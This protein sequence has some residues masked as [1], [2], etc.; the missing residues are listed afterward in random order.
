MVTPYA[1]GALVRAG[2][3]A[4]FVEI[5]TL[6]GAGGVLVLT[7][8][9]DDESLGCGAALAAACDTGVNVTVV[10]LTD[11]SASHP[12][13]EK[14]PPKRLAGLRAT[15]LEAA[16]GRLT[17]GSGGVRFLGC[18][19]QGVPAA[20][21]DRDSLVEQL[22]SLVDQ[23]GVT[24]LWTTWRQDPHIDHQQAAMLA[25]EVWDR[26]SHLVQWQF[27]IWGRFTDAGL[28]AGDELLRFAAAHYAGRKR[29]AIASHETQMTGLI[30][31]A[32]NGFVMDAAAQAHF[33]AFD[34]LFIRVAR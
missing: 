21:A 2:I 28:D 16:V 31:D 27:P 7:P 12:G 23:L 24:A 33:L 11:G 10:C 6:C 32:P 29:L 17:A 1:E 25:G 14:F 19:D 15:E 34:E 22:V 20:G 18:A 30:D 4:P 8:H 3:A 5:G 13:S 26:R 9:P